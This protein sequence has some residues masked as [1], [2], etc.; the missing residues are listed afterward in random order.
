MQ[1]GKENP[2]LSPL[3][4]EHLAWGLFYGKL[5]R[6]GLL[7]CTEASCRCVFPRPALTSQRAGWA[8]F[9]LARQ[10]HATSP[11]QGRG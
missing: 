5:N 11:F 2:G 6:F 3:Q 4:L 9:S 7:V 8:S 10:A 1:G